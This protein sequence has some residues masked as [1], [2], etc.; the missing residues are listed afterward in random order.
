MRIEQLMTE[1]PKSCR[2]DDTLDE[3]VRLMLDAD[4]G[5][6]PVTADDGSRHLVGIITDRD[7]CIAVERSGS[8]LKS[9]RVGWVMTS[10]IRAC[11]P[12]DPLAEAEAIMREQ[13]VRRLPVV[14]QSGHLIGLLSLTDLAREA[15][16]QS[17]SRWKEITYAEVGRTLAEICASPQSHG[18]SIDEPGVGPIEDPEN[19][20]GQA[21]RSWRPI[22]LRRSMG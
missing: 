20:P 11:N 16:R 15:A 8:T 2:P 6:L 10:A 14:D 22:G 12:E 18:S 5:C 1:S 9:L 4:C 7:I 21:A 19:R 13:S 3:A 17:A